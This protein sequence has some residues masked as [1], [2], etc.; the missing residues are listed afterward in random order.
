MLKQ[1]PKISSRKPPKTLVDHH[2]A[3]PAWGT[4]IPREF[5][6]KGNE[7]QG[8]GRGCR[9]SGSSQAMAGSLGHSQSP[10]SWWEE[11]DVCAATATR[12]T[13]SQEGWASTPTRPLT[14]CLAALCLHF[15]ARLTS[16]LKLAEIYSWEVLQKHQWLQ[17][18]HHFNLS[19]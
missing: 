9:M 6:L 18:A 3:H 11:A 2:R 16:H 4:L 8:T 7:S 15:L 17:W 19:T 1:G 5:L 10:R 12:V 14:S 13:H